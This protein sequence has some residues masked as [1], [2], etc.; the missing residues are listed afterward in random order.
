M[1]PDGAPHT[2]PASSGRKVALTVAGLLG[3]GIVGVAWWGLR[4]GETVQPPIAAPAPS[5]AA[6]PSAAS[7]EETET[8]AALPALDVSDDFFRALAKRV[9][10]D[11]NVDGW[12]SGPGLI[13]RLVATVSRLSEGESPAPLVAFLAPESGF[14]V[15]ELGTSTVIDPASWSRYD[16]VVG[17]LGRINAQQAA[18]AVKSMNPLLSAA[19][20]EVGRPGTTFATALNGA[21]T[22]LLAVPPVS[23][24]VEVVSKGAVYAY[25]NP[26]LENLSG[27]QKLLLRTGPENVKRVQLKVRELRDALG[28]PA[29]R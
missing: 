28:Y 5:T 21:F 17:L 12:L 1:T 2:P 16:A 9:M 3:L 22:S 20:R 14:K 27:A 29:K 4:H 19:W 25:A 24:N 8:A 15:K 7:D 13:R 26:E 23:T 11:A 6:A 10:G 18:L